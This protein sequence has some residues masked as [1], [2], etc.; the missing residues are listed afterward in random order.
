MIG[1]HANRG[2]LRLRS[3]AWPTRPE[4]RRK[5]SPAIGIAVVV[6]VLLVAGLAAWKV[7][8]LVNAPRSEFVNATISFAGLR[9]PAMSGGGGGRAGNP[10]AGGRSARSVRAPLLR[11]SPVTKSSLEMPPLPQPQPQA[12]LR[13]VIAVETLDAAPFTSVEP[14]SPPA[15]LF[16]EAVA[17]EETTGSGM[18][19]GNGRGP[20]VG[21]GSADGVAGTGT[22]TGA[23]V[24]MGEGDGAGFGGANYL[25]NPQ[26]QYPSIARQQGWEGTTVLRVEIRAN[27]LIGVIQIVQSTGH[28]V[29]DD[30]AIEAVRAARFQPA[31]HNGTPITSWAEVPVTFRLN[32]S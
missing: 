16:A 25:R 30:A 2:S 1:H 24:G 22:G 20:G 31:R 5:F 18:G 9:E 11:V 27:G 10:N 19:I 12:R 3:I 13:P 29:L 14:A 7:P 26:P 23:G 4:Q 6:H 8:Q 17:V 15:S 32:R 28:K 21:D